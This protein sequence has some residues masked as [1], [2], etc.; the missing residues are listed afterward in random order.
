MQQIVLHKNINSIKRID[1]T[2]YNPIVY[3][4]K[5]KL[6]QYER[7]ASEG[8]SEETIF[9]VLK[10]SRATYYR[11]KNNYRLYGLIGLEDESRK[12]HN[13]RQVSWTST[14]EQR[15]YKLRLKNPFYG[16]NKIATK[17]KELHGEKICKSLVGRIISKLLKQKKIKP[18]SYHLYKKREKRKR[19]FKGHAQ[20]WKYGMKAQRPGE[21]V[22][23]D[24]MT[25]FVSGFGYVK[26]FQAT[27]PTTKMTHHQAYKEATAQNAADFLA[28]VIALFPF[29]I[30]S[31]QTD[32]GSE[33]MAEFEDYC[34]RHNILLFI[35]P[36]RRPKYN[37]NVERGNCT[38]KYEFYYQYSREKPTLEVLRADLKKFT[39]KY[40]TDRPHQ[41]IGLLTPAAFY[42]SI[43]FKEAP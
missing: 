32:G 23:L 38:V 1:T 19:I 20:R 6:E 2:E 15:I 13:L 41:G 18:V 33:F 26:N 5:E 4:R 8:C 42:E 16:R 40:N 28:Q 21:L 24:H 39:H 9:E 34:R 35:L 12:P 36:P 3:E 25:T 43:K 22:Q 31:I 27:D 10:I 29:P 17:Y 7:L 30:I 37:G 14:I 11:W